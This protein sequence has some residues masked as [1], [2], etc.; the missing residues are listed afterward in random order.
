MSYFIHPRSVKVIKMDN[1]AVEKDTVRGVSTFLTTY[2]VIIGVSI[3]LLTFD[4][5]D[6]I[7]NFT[8]VAATF[9]NIGP[10]FE[11][12]GPTRNFSIFSP[13]AKYV[14]MFDMLAGRLELY[15]ILMLFTPSVWRKN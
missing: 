13:M 5:L 4:N 8:A 11:L 6:M 3:L 1:K 9:N 12:V 10:G 7:T 14:L 2:V 15:P